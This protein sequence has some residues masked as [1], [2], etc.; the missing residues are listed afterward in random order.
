VLLPATASLADLHQAIQVLF[1][2]DGD[3]LHAFTV[4]Q[5]RY[6]DPLYDLD[7]LEMGDEYQMRLRDVFT[8]S[9]SKIGYE[10]DFGASWRH[11]VV[12]EKTIGRDPTRDYPICTAFKGDSPV[13]YWSEDEPTDPEP[14][15][16][17]AV[18]RRLHAPEKDEQ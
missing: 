1:G 18:N 17:A 14:F 16:L 7:R 5:E 6:S 4:G 10:Y 11:D 8:T 15:D 9:T 13:E 3:H 12:L 2:W